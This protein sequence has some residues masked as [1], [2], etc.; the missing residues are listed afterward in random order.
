MSEQPIALVGGLDEALGLSSPGGG[1]WLRLGS[2]WKL[3]LLSIAVASAAVAF[4]LTL[5]AGF[6]AYPGW[7]AVQKADFILGPIVVGPYWM[8][9]RPGNRLG[10]LLIVL[11]LFGIPYILESS[12]DPTLFSIGVLTEFPLFLMITIVILAFPSGRLDGIPE[13]LIIALQ[14][15]HIALVEAVFS[16]PP[17]AAGFTISNCRVACPGAT[18]GETSF[19]DSWLIRDHILVAMPVEIGRASCRERV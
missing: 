12:T 2:P 14:V 3:A 1:S 10:L 15:A 7:L 8:N 18:V 13:R 16:F 17:H 9:R 11:G 5:R 4:W 19:T 6:L